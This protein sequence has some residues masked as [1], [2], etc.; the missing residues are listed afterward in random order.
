MEM[1]SAK[2]KITSPA[3]LAALV[4]RRKAQGDRVV[5]TNGVFDLLHVG[6]VTL[7]EKARA[8]GDCLIVGINS[9]ASVRR[10]KGPTRPL[11]PLADRLKMLAA[12]SSVSYVTSFAEDTPETL[13]RKLKPTVLVKGG[14]YSLSQIVGRNLV[15]RVV[16][17]PLVKGRSTSAL[18]KKIVKAY[19][20]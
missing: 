5:F 17:V 8:L 10:L 13:I 12:L 6:H 7:L 15:K 2:R 3:R 1:V 20:R 4:A 16:R 9:D 19:G 11:A 18:V 14:D